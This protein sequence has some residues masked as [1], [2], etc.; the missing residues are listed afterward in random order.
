MLLPRLLQIKVKIQ[1]TSLCLFYSPAK[2]FHFSIAFLFI[3]VLQRRYL[4]LFTAHIIGRPCLFDVNFTSYQC[5]YLLSIRGWVVLS[6]PNCPIL[7]LGPRVHPSST[8][9]HPADPCQ[10]ILLTHS[11][12]QVTVFEN[13]NL[14]NCKFRFGKLL[15]S[16][17]IQNNTKPVKLNIS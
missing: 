8:P 5:Q 2:Y 13:E 10:T 12:L 17:H 9:R 4:E 11:I 1:I 3:V 16:Y 14:W 7:I 15:L 6:A